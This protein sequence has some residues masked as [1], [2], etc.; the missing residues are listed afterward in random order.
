M[1]LIAMVTP[2]TSQYAENWRH[3]LSRTDW[4]DA[5]F[6]AD[7]A[8]TLERGCFDMMF[9]P[10]ALAV[11]EDHTGDYATTVRTG[12]KGTIYL[13][14]VVVAAVAA[15]ATQHLGLG[16][17]VSTTF[18]PPYA[19]ARTLLTLDHLS[20]GRTAWNIV[21]STTDA[22]ARNLGLPAMPPKGERY[23]HADRVVQTVLDLWDTWQ[24]D[25]LTLDRP[26]RVFAAPARIGRI[27]ARGDG[28]PLSRGPITLP[29]S[30]QGRPVLM[31]A[32]ASDRG[33]AFAAR[34]AEVVFASADS[35]E[36]MRALRTELRER[37]AAHGRDPDDLRV[38]PAVQPVVG[39]TDA[40]A[41]RRVTELEDLLDESEVLTVLGRLLHAAPDEL[42]PDADAA[43]LIEA[44][45]GSTG[46]DGFEEMLLR[47][48][49]AEGLT[50]RDLAVRQAMTQLKPQ[51]TGSP[52]TVA[53]Y[54]CDLFD[55]G[56][57]DG[58][59]VMSA[60][61]PSSL[62]EFVDGVVPELQRRGRFR[63]RYDGTTLRDRLGPSCGDGW[64]APGSR[65]TSAALASSS[66]Q[67]RTRPPR[68]PPEGRPMT[69]PTS[70]SLRAAPGGTT[71]AAAPT[72]S[73]RDHRWLGLAVIGVAQLMVV[74]D[75]TIVNIALPT[76]Q[77]DLGF[78]NDQRQWVVTAY[79][80]AFGSLLLLG[81]RLSDLFGRRPAFVTGLIGFAA[82]S[83]LGGAATSF[84]WL[85]AARA[86]QGVFG[87][88]LAP[89][90]LSLLTTTFTDPRERG[91]AFG[92][93]GAI[94]G[95]GA[96]IG[97]L[98]GGVLTEYASWRWCLY[99]NI[100]IA[101]VGVVGAFLYLHAVPRPATRPHI[102]LPGVLT[103]TLG[104]V[105][106]VY[107]FSNAEVNGWDDTLTAVC[108]VLGVA[109]LVGF[110]LLQRRVAH[111]L[112]PLRVVLDRDRG[113]AFLAIG[114][115]AIGMFGLFLFLTYYLQLTLGFSALQTGFAFLPMSASIM[116]SSTLVG[117]R[118][119]PRV[120][121][122]VLV[123]V[124]GS[125]ATIGMVL[126]TRI[127]VDTAYATTVLPAIVVLG[128]GLGLIFSS[129]FATATSG[130]ERQDAGVASATVNTMQQVGGS[131]GTALLST[132]A[133]N[134]TADYLVGRDASPAVQA[135]AALEGYQTAF[136]ASAIGFALVTVVGATV[137]RGQ[138][139]R[140]ARAAAAADD[141]RTGVAAEA[142][143]GAH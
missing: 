139:D 12:G 33:K 95:S 112:L 74:L 62:T 79:S 60:L 92:I 110:V 120:G 101:A 15:G 50:V 48:C 41:H 19:I 86:L 77:A 80:L 56:A 102:D 90:A 5:R 131:I 57:A 100:L 123:T 66:V 115:V 3:P 103:V 53:E 137:L 18:L 83:A 45:R 111:P 63:R 26:G 114:L 4:L 34:W 20:G 81:G 68:C 96:A 1:H 71:A 126:L 138:R 24:P 27:P 28:P 89:A 58:F 106:I 16:A 76:A 128:A 32:G 109:L 117:A 6:Y 133:A 129:S 105:A 35:P 104:L 136:W 14:P 118:L 36:A 64:S 55:S 8:R 142:P 9:L 13:D 46:S 54:L 17:T 65:T 88:L 97:L 29:R 132:L 121:P 43:R 67:R 38:L 47:A 59:V 119:L 93:F 94:A 22:E 73:G 108:L 10:D 30:P 44:H 116:L 72:S 84:E 99:V 7:L 2:P 113:G 49:R 23:D 42:D 85:V 69:D 37:A 134:A 125:L 130:V 124:G 122:R 11:P 21:T 75:S 87:A 31:Q 70:S 143:V 52:A 91:K 127:G 107:G 25:A 82:A 140:V 39:P 141:D 98:L 61:Y 78:D 51:P 135:A 40:A